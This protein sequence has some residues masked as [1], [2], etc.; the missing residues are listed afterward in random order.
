[1]ENE[2]KHLE[3]CKIFFCVRIRCCVSL[4]TD[5]EQRGKS[6]SQITTPRVRNETGAEDTGTEYARSISDQSS[7]EEDGSRDRSTMSRAR[8]NDTVIPVD[9]GETTTGDG[10]WDSRQV[11]TMLTRCMQK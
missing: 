2:Q 1:M 10:Y 5:V 11:M 6:Q 8:S 9:V 7:E 3:F 4:N